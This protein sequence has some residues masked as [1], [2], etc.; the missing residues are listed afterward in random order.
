MS[1]TEDQPEMVLAPSPPPP[2]MTVKSIPSGAPVFTV[3][4]KVNEKA[5]EVKGNVEFHGGS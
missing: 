3:K 2:M 1:E 4:Q 5:L